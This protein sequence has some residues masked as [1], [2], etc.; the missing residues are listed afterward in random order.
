MI[1]CVVSIQ[2]TE[3]DEKDIVSRFGRAV[4]VVM[5]FL[6]VMFLSMPIA[7]VGSSFSQTWF[8][9]ETIILIEKVR[10]RMRQQGYTTDDLREVFDELDEDGSGSIEFHEFKKMLEA[11]H[12]FGSLATCK[13][14]F[15]H[16]D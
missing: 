14:L 5:M 10:S 3:V 15:N 12:F 4:A 8:T 16:F 13:K 11:F 6:G 2:I 7:I 9:K 1:V